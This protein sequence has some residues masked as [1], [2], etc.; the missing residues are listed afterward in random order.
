MQYAPNR[1]FFTA[2]STEQRCLWACLLHNTAVSIQRNDC[3]S[4]YIVSLQ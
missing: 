2:V 4:V 3:A 1:V